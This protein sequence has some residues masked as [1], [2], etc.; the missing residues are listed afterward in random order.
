MRRGPSHDPR[1]S[2]EKT[3]GHWTERPG[4]VTGVR[5]V[6][7]G[8][9][10]GRRDSGLVYEVDSGTKGTVPNSEVGLLLHLTPS[11]FSPTLTIPWSGPSTLF[12]RKI[13]PF[14]RSSTKG[15][16][17]CQTPIHPEVR[18]THR[19]EVLQR[20]ARTEENVVTRDG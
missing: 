2:E 3:E 5:N 9:P 11:R 15:R 12:L 19:P 13:P 6:R 20:T 16:P 8:E 10:R 7:T 1:T 18:P 17:H 4:V 14:N